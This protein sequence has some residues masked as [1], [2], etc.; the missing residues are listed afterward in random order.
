MSNLSDILFFPIELR[1]KAYKSGLFRRCQTT[2]PVI[3]VGNIV[4]GG[5]GKTPTVVLI[6]EILKK[7][8]IGPAILTRGYKR[9]ETQRIILWRDDDTPWELCGDEPKLLSRILRDVPIVVHKNRCESAKTISSKCNVILLDDGF[10]YLKIKRSLD[11]VMLTGVEHR[12]GIFP[13]GLRRDGLWRLRTLGEENLS[14][15]LI[16][17][18]ADAEL[19]NIIPP[20]VQKFRFYTIPEGV[21][22]VNDWSKLD[23][24][25]VL[26]GKKVYAI[27]AVARPVRF[28]FTLRHAGARIAG[29]KIFPD[30]YTISQQQLLSIMKSAQQC[31]AEIVV[32]T[33]KD[34]VRIERFA[35]K[36]MLAV[37]IK[38]VVEP[39]DEFEKLILNVSRP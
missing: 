38:A 20:N 31:G 13:L 35:P 10:Q 33:E 21:H 36:E 16:P 17:D 18:G 3:S 37:R 9:S 27:A 4:L 24:V 30:H 6:A 29:H 26:W 15:A 11:I 12:T 5:S 23:S 25:E 22:P 14:V 32:T 19:V 7:H 8:E 28:L 34:A 1:W 2:V 39:M